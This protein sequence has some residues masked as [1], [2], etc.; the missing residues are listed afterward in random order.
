MRQRDLGM[1]EGAFFGSTRLHVDFLAAVYRSLN[2]YSTC[3]INIRHTIYPR[4]LTKL[5]DKIFTYKIY[6]LIFKDWRIK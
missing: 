6:A 2:E 3:A 1:D 4:L 5:Y